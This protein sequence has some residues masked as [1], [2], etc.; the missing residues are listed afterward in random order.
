MILHLDNFNCIQ[1]FK[2]HFLNIYYEVKPLE[3]YTSKFHVSILK[4]KIIISNEIVPFITCS[5]FTFSFIL[6]SLFFFQFCFVYF[7]IYDAF[8]KVLYINAPDQCLDNL[9]NL[10]CIQIQPNEFNRGSLTRG[11]QDKQSI[12][13]TFSLIDKFS[14]AWIM[15]QVD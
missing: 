5:L 15:I 1:S 9:F 14:I 11:L 7:I 6:F 4:K 8:L 13:F 10:K 3:K 12:L 2:V